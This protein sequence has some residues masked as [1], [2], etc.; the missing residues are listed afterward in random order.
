MPLWYRTGFSAG[1]QT[2]VSSLI[3]PGY[4]LFIWKR[5]GA[6]MLTLLFFSLLLLTCVTIHRA[7][8]Y[9]DFASV[10][11]CYTLAVLKLN[12][13]VE[14]RSVRKFNYERDTEVDGVGTLHIAVTASFLLSSS[15]AA[16]KLFWVH[17]CLETAR[18]E[19]KKRE[20]MRK[21]KPRR[22][23]LSFTEDKSHKGWRRKTNLRLQ[24]QYMT[25]P[26]NPVTRQL[27][28]YF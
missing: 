19:Y 26:R 24:T 17:I 5:I 1:K 18:E 22:E 13:K 15:G 11:A 9:E 3:L 7:V 21:Q 12:M 4:W 2:A 28:V 16:S 10:S 23:F 20:N 25:V 8:F 14:K 6:K 27:K